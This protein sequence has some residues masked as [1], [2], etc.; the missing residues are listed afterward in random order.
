MAKFD[1]DTAVRSQS[2]GAG[3]LG[4]IADGFGAPACMQ[5]LAEDVLAIL[6]FPILISMQKT[7]S[8]VQER[9]D[10]WIDEH[11]TDLNIGL[12]ISVT[13]TPGGQIQFTSRNSAFGL[14]L[15]GMSLLAEVGA[16][17]NGIAEFGANLYESGKAI[18]EEV[19]AAKDCVTGFF[20][21]QKFSGT[22]SA[23]SAP[24]LT[25]EQYAEIA[26]KKF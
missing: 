10:M 23:E 14:D 4:S 8:D 22:N 21:T 3:V 6:P 25:N 18:A 7:T 19:K 1:V 2:E 5:D 24:A 9:I 11:L 12:G 20:N 15:P 16:W 26:E 17:V 13:I